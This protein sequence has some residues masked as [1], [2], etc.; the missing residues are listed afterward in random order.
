MP[1]T[2]PW[3]ERDP[4]RGVTERCRLS[5]LTNIAPSIM[6]PNA[7]GGGVAGSQQ[8]S[9]LYTGAQ[10]TLG[11]LT[12]YL[13]FASTQCRWSVWTALTVLP[14]TLVLRALHRR[15]CARLLEWAG[16]LLSPPAAAWCR[17]LPAARRGGMLHQEEKRRSSR[18]LHHPGTAP[19]SSPAAA[20]AGSCVG[21]QLRGPA[22]AQAVD[23]MRLLDPRVFGMLQPEVLIEPVLGRASLSGCVN[24]LK[25]NWKSQVGKS[26]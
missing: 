1:D 16:G 17:L 24:A 3:C 19:S 23:G 13:T 22:V 8:M 9:K 26:S 11:D 4:C 20:W 25:Q 14:S 12:P 18:S 2:G 10:I 7:G 15:D 5:W 6:S 21:R